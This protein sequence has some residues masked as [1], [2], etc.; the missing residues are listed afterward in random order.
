MSTT[1][2][3]FDH[4]ATIDAAPRKGFLQRFIEMRTRQGKARV[5]A[6]FARMSDTQLADLGF[7]PDQVRQ[8][9]RNSTIPDGYW[10]L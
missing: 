6:T 10:G 7:S 3:T 4:Q 1:T 5:G 2:A 8:V 9:R